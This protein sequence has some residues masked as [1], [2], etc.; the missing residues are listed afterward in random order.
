MTALYHDPSTLGKAIRE[1]S[2]VIF[3]RSGG[4]LTPKKLAAELGYK[5]QASAIKWAKEHGVPMVRA[6]AY[7]TGFEAELVAQAIVQSRGMV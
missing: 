2:K 7:K 1:K 4:I 6:G 5:D 3:E